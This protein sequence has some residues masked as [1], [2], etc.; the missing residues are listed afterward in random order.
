M[1]DSFGLFNKIASGGNAAG[2]PVA[3]LATSTSVP[4][5]GRIGYHEYYVNLESWIQSHRGIMT[6][7]PEVVWVPGPTYEMGLAVLAVAYGARCR[8]SNQ[9]PPEYEAIPFE[10]VDLSELKPVDPK[11]NGLMP[12]VLA[13]QRRIEEQLAPDGLNRGFAFS[14]GPMSIAQT[15]TG[16][17][18]LMLSTVDQPELLSR[19]LNTLTETSIRWLH[20]QLDVMRNPSGIFIGDDITGL[21]SGECCQE[22]V[23]PCLRRIADEFKGL[24]RIYHN[25]TVCPQLLGILPDNGFDV[26]HFSHEIGMAEMIEA[27]AG[28]IVPMGNLPPLAIGM[29]GTPEEVAIAAGEC[30]ASA[31]QRDIILSWGG[32]MAGE[33]PFH[34]VDA[35]CRAAQNSKS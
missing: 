22:L 34:N 11:E 5:F 26:W 10:L 24:L 6:R 15:L 33:T 35:L 2:S 4:H 23:I 27:A 29:N 21:I 7:F 8:F 14:W 9:R 18:E 12:L 1:T 30:I 17:T 3:L 31:G 19:V 28:R 16:M 25:D 32:S 20:A 13:N